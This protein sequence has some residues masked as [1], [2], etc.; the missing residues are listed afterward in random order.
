MGM[1]SSRRNGSY[2]YKLVIPE[3]GESEVGKVN[4]MYFSFAMEIPG[5]ARNIL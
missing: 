3:T 5:S 4:Q 2:K 1:E